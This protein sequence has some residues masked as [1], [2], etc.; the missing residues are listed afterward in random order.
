MIGSKYDSAQLRALVTESERLAR[1]TQV[2]IDVTRCL[3]EV[4]ARLARALDEVDLRRTRHNK[5]A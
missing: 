3:S 4:D 1:K 2:L 5:A